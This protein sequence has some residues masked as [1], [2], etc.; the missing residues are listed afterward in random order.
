MVC[1]YCDDCFVCTC[2]D[3]LGVNVSEGASRKGHLCKS[4]PILP[5]PLVV[6]LALSA[7]R[8]HDRNESS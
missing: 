2:H 5:S 8:Q 4:F 6:C 3:R 7:E 1:V